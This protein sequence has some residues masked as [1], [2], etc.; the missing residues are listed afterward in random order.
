MAIVQ[1]NIEQQHDEKQTSKGKLR[2][3]VTCR[4]FLSDTWIWPGWKTTCAHIGHFR[5]AGALEYASRSRSKRCPMRRALCSWSAMWPQSSN[6]RARCSAR[7]SGP[8]KS[9]FTASPKVSFPTSMFI[10][11]LASSTFI[12]MQ[13]HCSEPHHRSLP[14][15][16]GGWGCSHPPRYFFYITNWEFF[17]RLSLQTASSLC[18]RLSS[19]RFQGGREILRALCFFD[20]TNWEL[21][22]RPSLQTASRL[23]C[24]GVHATLYHRLSYSGMECQAVG[25][26]SL[27]EDGSRH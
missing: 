13:R 6:T 20:I 27:P 10:P 19:L 12:S 9:L 1:V 3:P 7:R 18:F 11:A 21:F 8:C 24:K 16:H 4:N 26:C 17:C 15:Q 2:Y 22:H 25:S 5:F 23:N 14:S